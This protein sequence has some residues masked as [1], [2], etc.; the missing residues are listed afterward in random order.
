[1]S[2]EVFGGGDEEDL[3][4]A[5]SRYGWSLSEDDKWINEADGDGPLTDEEMWKWLQDKREG[6]AEDYAEW[7]ARDGD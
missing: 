4:D 5:V 1:M 2:L 6:D 3:L 7:E